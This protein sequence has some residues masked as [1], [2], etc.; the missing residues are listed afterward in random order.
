MED[1][2]VSNAMSRCLPSDLHRPNDRARRRPEVAGQDAAAPNRTRGLP[3]SAGRSRT[4]P[5]W[6]VSPSGMSMS[7][8]RRG[9]DPPILGARSDR[10]TVDSGCGNRCQ[11]STAEDEAAVALLEAGCEEGVLPRGL[12]GGRAVDRRELELAERGPPSPAGDTVGPP[13]GCSRLGP[14]VTRLRPPRSR[15]T[16]GAPSPRTTIAPAARAGRPVDSGHGRAAPYGCAGSVA[17]STRAGV[18]EST[19]SVP[20]VGADGRRARRCRLADRAQPIDGTRQGELGATEP[21]DEVAA[22]DLTPVLQGPQHRVDAGEATLDALGERRLP[23]EHTVPFEQLEGAGV[24]RLGGGGPGLEE[25]GDE[26]PSTGTCGRTESVDLSGP[27]AGPG[28]P[29]VPDPGWVCGWPRHRV[30]CLPFEATTRPQRA[31]RVVGDLARSRPG[32][33]ARPGR[34]GRRR[35]GR[36]PEPPPPG[37]TRTTRPSLGHARPQHHAQPGS[38]SSGPCSPAATRGRAGSRRPIWSRKKRRMRPS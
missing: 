4:A 23:G 10:K 31:E 28:P 27:G 29:R 17:A 11:G 1:E 7:M 9:R 32:P 13:A 37:R 26:R 15:Y 35:A 6:I 34:L 18:A 5:R 12:G 25:R 20:R 14:K 19:G 24:G 38:C 3:P 16:R 33:T 30:G 36:P 2:P 22:P 8:P 21:G